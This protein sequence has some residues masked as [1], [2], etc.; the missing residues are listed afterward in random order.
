M[1]TEA[2]SHRGPFDDPSDFEHAA[3]RAAAGR[4]TL[5]LYI[6]GNTP[7]SR[8]AVANIKRVCERYLHER[9]DLEVIDVYQQ[10]RLAREQQL[11]AAPTLVK[12]R[13]L[14]MRRLVGDMSNEDRVLVGL[15]LRRIA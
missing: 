12:H 7:R 6:S 10:P 15:D 4:Y 2:A 11:V 8:S 1:V 13:P 9:Y 5:R 3:A 14:P